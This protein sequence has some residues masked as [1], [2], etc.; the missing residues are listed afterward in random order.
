MKLTIPGGY[1]FPRLIQTKDGIHATLGAGSYIVDAELQGGNR[2]HILIGNYCSIA[3]NIKIVGGNNHNRKGIT[4]YPFDAFDRPIAYY[5]EPAFT[6]ENHYQTVIGSDVWICAN[7]YIRA[8]IYISDGAIIGANAVVAKDVPPYSVV[9]GNPGRVVKYR[10]N[11]DMIKKLL[12]MRWWLWDNKTIDERRPFMD[13][14]IDFV[15]KFYIEREKPK[16]NDISR[17]IKKRKSEGKKIYSVTTDFSDPNSL[18]KEILESYLRAFNADSEVVLVI[19]GTNDKELQMIYEAV[20][21]IKHIPLIILT[22]KSE[23]E[24][25][26]ANSDIFFTTRDWISSRG[27]E[28]ANDYNVKIRSAVDYDVFNTPPPRKNSA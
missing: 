25:V 10:F 28:F 1:R 24:S 15:E 21:N 22:Y 23:L 12:K 16:E 19:M 6:S 18:T 3:N 7:V 14:P 26:I 27:V 13:K 5:T 2:S 8:G 20:K 17:L 4:T 11:E 9:V